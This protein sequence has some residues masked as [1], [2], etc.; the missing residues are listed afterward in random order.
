ML[1]LLPT[2]LRRRAAGVRGQGSHPVRLKGSWG[3]RSRSLPLE[4]AVRPSGCRPPRRSTTA[5]EDA[6][7]Q[8][9]KRTAA[10]AETEAWARRRPPVPLRVVVRGRWEC[11]EK[12]CRVNEVALQMQGPCTALPWRCRQVG[13]LVEDAGAGAATPTA[14]KVNVLLRRSPFWN[15]SLGPGVQPG[16]LRLRGA[17][18][19]SRADE[20]SQ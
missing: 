6:R 1:L 20:A 15:Q 3:P 5:D 4:R 8:C 16:R 10:V 11:H 17:R 14:F 12:S 18:V 13:C 2:A 7:D 19:A 9:G